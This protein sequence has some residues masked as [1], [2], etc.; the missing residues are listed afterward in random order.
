MNSFKP[1]T[2]NERWQ[3]GDRIE[4]PE[5]DDRGT[6]LAIEGYQLIIECGHGIMIYGRQKTMERMEW[7]LVAS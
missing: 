2:L 3:V 4:G 6:I 7:K 5:P 1:S